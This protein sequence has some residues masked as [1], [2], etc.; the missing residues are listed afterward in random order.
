MHSEHRPK[1]RKQSKIG[2]DTLSIAAHAPDPQEV[3][4]ILGSPTPERA[5]VD[6]FADWVKNFR[7]MAWATSRNQRLG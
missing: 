3:D 5:N 7:E 6:D 2:M 1:K 4:A